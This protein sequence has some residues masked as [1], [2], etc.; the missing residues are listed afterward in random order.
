MKLRI[1]VVDDAAFVRDLVKK[2]VRDTYPGCELHEAI[3]GRKA[4]TLLNQREI[5][6]VL[7]DWE[8]PEVSGIEVLQWMRA[9]ER[10]KKTPFMMITSRGDR[11]HV[12]KAV[13][14]GVSDYIGKPFTREN[15]VAKMAKVVAKHHGVKPGQGAPGP[16]AHANQSADVLTAR[17]A[18]PPQAD[19]GGASVLVA[20]Q[21]AGNET[22]EKSTPEPA[23]GKAKPKAKGVA[24][25]R[26]GSG[27]TAKVVLKDIN[28]QE[29]IGVFRREG[30]LPAL[31]EPVVLDIVDQDS[32]DVA[33]ING[34]VRMMQAQ[35]PHPDAE[36][37]QILIRYVDDDQ[38]KLDVLSRFIAKVR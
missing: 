33:R 19:L 26:F 20:G 9:D 10:Y 13:E 17:P 30:A 7:C 16:S 35:E 27:G 32:G 25:I 31:L 38:D 18:S 8:M 14:A 24:S 4:I 15:F 21:A 22:P 3:D 36:T 29:L 2:A 1:L 23:R 6:L 11:D 28:L 5:N 37:I 12:M 34:Y